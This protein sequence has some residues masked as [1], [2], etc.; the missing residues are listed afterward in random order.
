MSA[1]P[2]SFTEL[3]HRVVQESSEPLTVAQI[4]ER[5]QAIRPITTRNP[6]QT[7][8]NAVSASYLIVPTG[9]GRYG[10]KMRLIDGALLRHTLQ[11]AEFVGRVLLWD[12]DL[13]DAL[14]PTFFAPPQVQRPQPGVDQPAGRRGHPLRVGVYHPRHLGIPRG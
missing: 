14:W 7:I 10:W 12:K 2:P 3:T 9:E 11:E 6:K 8:R 1:K 4:I 5:V 13:R